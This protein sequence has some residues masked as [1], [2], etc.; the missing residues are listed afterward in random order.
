MAGLFLDIRAES[1]V[2]FLAT[3]PSIV[4]LSESLGPTGTKR[5]QG[6]R[7]EGNE[8]FPVRQDE[9][10]GLAEMSLALHIKPGFQ[11]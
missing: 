4:S 6:K 10:G 8:E 9:V 2:A 11:A 7:E 3:L 1:S 5:R